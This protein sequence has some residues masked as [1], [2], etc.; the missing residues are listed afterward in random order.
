ML[1]RFLAITLAC[2]LAASAV[3]ALAADSAL[4]ALLRA[5]QLT[6]TLG[7]LRFDVLNASSDE[8][9]ETLNAFLAPLTAVASADAQGGC[10]AFAANGEVIAAVRADDVAG[11]PQLDAVARLFDEILP[12]LYDS[13]FVPD[14][15]PEPELKNASVKNLPRSTQRTTVTVTDAQLSLVRPAAA[16]VLAALTAHLPCSG[17]M[18]RWAQDMNA[19]NSLTLKRLENADGEAIAWQLTGRIASGGKDPR[20]LTLYGGVSGLNAYI[21]LKLPARSGR[22]NLDCTVSIARRAG[23]KQNTIEGTVSFKRT[24]DRETLTIKDTVSLKSVPGGGQETW[25]GSVKRE[26]TEDGVKTVWTLKPALTAQ[27]NSVAGSVI[28]TKKYAQTQVWQAAI[29][30]SLTA[31][32]AVLPEPSDEAAFLQALT[33]YFQDTRARLSPDRQRL[34]DH[35]LRS[36]AWTAIP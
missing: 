6:L 4:D 12:S 30:L 9:L 8:G 36:D 10:M 34:L 32:P 5:E 35:M 18:V 28:L 1:K 14:E 25:S 13:C 20:Q 2:L 31:Q 24:L 26:L 7:P 11:F 15:P 22:N 21:S 29:G 3:P 19:V 23:K 17:A 33:R 27:G 16:E